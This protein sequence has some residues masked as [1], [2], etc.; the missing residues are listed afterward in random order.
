[1]IVGLYMFFGTLPIIFLIL[2]NVL[3]LWELLSLL[4]SRG[5]YYSTFLLK[6]IK[7]SIIGFVATLPIVLI[8][9]IF[10]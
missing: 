5:T 2:A 9:G 10:V 6:V 1:M 3:L 7:M 4:F 8:L